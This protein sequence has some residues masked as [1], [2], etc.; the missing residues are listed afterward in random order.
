MNVRLCYKMG[1]IAHHSIINSSAFQISNTEFS[2]R[3]Y[4]NSL[5]ATRWSLAMDLSYEFCLKL[6]I[7]FGNQSKF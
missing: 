1:K 5:N 6:L 7:F 3:T 4:E 2:I